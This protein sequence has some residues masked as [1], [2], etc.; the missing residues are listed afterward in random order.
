MVLF[1]YESSSCRE[2]GHAEWNYQVLFFCAVPQTA[3]CRS[4]P[5][6]TSGVLTIVCL[7]FAST[8]MLL[9]RPKT[10]DKVAPAL[11]MMTGFPLGRLSVDG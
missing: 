11:F 7:Q 4:A 10:Y 5:R 3:V 6:S 9:T 8:R 1:D 2:L